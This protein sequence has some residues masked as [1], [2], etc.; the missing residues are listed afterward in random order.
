MFDSENGESEVEES[1]DNINY[2]EEDNL[3]KAAK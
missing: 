2:N 1:D 3:V